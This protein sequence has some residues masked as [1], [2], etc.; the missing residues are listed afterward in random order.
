MVF[1]VS[2]VLY[3]VPLVSSLQ[4]TTA[5]E[6]GGNFNS[7]FPPPP[8]FPP[9]PPSWNGDTNAILR[10]AVFISLDNQFT[11]STHFRRVLGLYGERIQTR[12][13]LEF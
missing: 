2:D 7:R 8:L 6:D 5:S 9:P 12:Y 10:E 13:C 4:S 11:V 3:N 1:L